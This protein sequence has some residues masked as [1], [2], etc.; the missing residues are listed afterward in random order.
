MPP[1]R[2]VNRSCTSNR[3]MVPSTILRQLARLRWRERLLRFSWGSARWLAVA[4]IV[5]ALA[6]LADWLGDRFTD[7]PWGLRYAV[8]GLQILVAAFLL[9]VWVAR[10]V[11]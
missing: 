3:L 10:P 5:L 8:A 11:L 2:N 6:C 7:T 9:A 1:A 4:L